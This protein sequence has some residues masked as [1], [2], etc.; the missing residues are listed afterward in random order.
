MEQVAYYSK[1][2]DVSS[3]DNGKSENYQISAV[4]ILVQVTIARMNHIRYKEFGAW[5]SKLYHSATCQ[6]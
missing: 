4:C 1:L 2:S 6:L 3:A 5:Y